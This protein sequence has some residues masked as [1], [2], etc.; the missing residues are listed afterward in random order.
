MAQTA[1]I[2]HSFDAIA[3]GDEVTPYSVLREELPVKTME[4][5]LDGWV[6]ASQVNKL[7]LTEGDVVYID[8]GED[9][10]VQPG[11]IFNVLRMGAIAIDPASKKKVQLPNETIGRLVVIRTKPKTSTALIIQSRHSVQIGDGI[12]TITE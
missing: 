3:K 10:H 9:D 2:T 11:H 5:R 1:L 4:E 12:T 6:V 8:R 7:E